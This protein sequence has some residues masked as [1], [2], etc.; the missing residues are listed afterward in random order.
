MFE[1]YIH[2][3]STGP[4]SGAPKKW[5][6]GWFDTTSYPKTVTLPPNNNLK[7]S[8]LYLVSIRYYISETK[9]LRRVKY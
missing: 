7:A 3:V 1:I 2:L 5:G 8:T 4:F 9:T 6:F